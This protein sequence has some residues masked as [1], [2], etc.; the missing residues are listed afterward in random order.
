M[1][2][3]RYLPDCAED[4][5]IFWDGSAEVWRSICSLR[6]DNCYVS[7]DNPGTVFVWGVPYLLKVGHWVGLDLDGAIYSIKEPLVSHRIEIELL[8]AQADKFLAELYIHEDDN[9]Y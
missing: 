5:L 2:R 3:L 6:W 9:D 8:G 7:T 1:L 4:V